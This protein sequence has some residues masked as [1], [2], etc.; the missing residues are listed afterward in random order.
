VSVVRLEIT[1]DGV[2]IASLSGRKSFNLF[3]IEMRD[4]LIGTLETVQRHPDVRALLLRA[5]GDHFSAGADLAEFG[6]ARDVFEARSIRGRR[7]PWSTLWELRVP[8]VAAL[9]GAVM[10]SGLEMALLCDLRICRPDARLALP[11]S[12]LGMLPAAGG[13]QSLT[14]VVGAAAALPLVLL[15]Q[16][17]TA[18]E[19]LA[20]GIVDEVSDEHEQRALDVAISFARLPRSASEAAK[21]ALRLAQ[22]LPLPQGLIAERSLARR[23]N[24][25]AG[26]GD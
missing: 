19:A 26:A 9:H 1:A 16:T 13:T 25:L 22:D 11:E 10:G 23:A 14:R 2:A 5:D 7:D 12:R 24:A 15:G 6:S 20:A 4:E 8:A 21:E 18:I 3:D 17:L